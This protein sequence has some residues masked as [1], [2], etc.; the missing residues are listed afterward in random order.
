MKKSSNHATGGH[1]LTGIYGL[2]IRTLTA[3]INAG[4]LLKS[5][6]T[7][8]F[9]ELA[10]RQQCILAALVHMTGDGTINDIKSF[11]SN[12]ILTLLS[13]PAASVAGALL[14]LRILNGIFI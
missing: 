13:G 6:S 1:E 5:I 11:R 12:P 14:F 10:L 9:V 3:A 7:A 2:E 4:I 8:T